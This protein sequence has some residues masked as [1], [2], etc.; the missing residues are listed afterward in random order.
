ML[1]V[2]GWHPTDKRSKAAAGEPPA[3]VALHP[4]TAPAPAPLS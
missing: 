1:A 3:A 4:S 2:W